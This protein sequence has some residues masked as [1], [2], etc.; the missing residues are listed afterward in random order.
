MERGTIFAQRTYGLEI[1]VNKIIILLFLLLF[2][3]VGIRNSLEQKFIL[4]VFSF[5]GHLRA[6]ELGI[7]VA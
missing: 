1:L 5:Q 7:K 3:V 6:K 2:V 4:V